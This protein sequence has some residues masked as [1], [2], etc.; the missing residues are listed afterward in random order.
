MFFER[1]FVKTDPDNSEA[2]ANKKT[3]HVRTIEQIKIILLPKYGLYN[4]N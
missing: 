2:H 3:C 1:I 4:S